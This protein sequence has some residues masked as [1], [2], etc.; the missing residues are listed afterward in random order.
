VQVKRGNTNRWGCRRLDVAAAAQ[1]Q[2]GVAA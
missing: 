1:R 2:A